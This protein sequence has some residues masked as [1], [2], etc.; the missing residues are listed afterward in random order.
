ME[1][2]GKVSSQASRPEAQQIDS[3]V[4]APLT[5]LPQVLRR[6]IRNGVG[7]DTPCRRL[8]VGAGQILDGTAMGGCRRERK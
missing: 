7:G 8:D 4:E 3:L 2:N 1:E 5:Q 6:S